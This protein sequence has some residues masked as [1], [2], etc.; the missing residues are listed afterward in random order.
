MDVVFHITE[1]PQIF[2]RNVLL[3]GLHYTR[4]ATV[5]RAI[6]L[7]SGDALNQT[8]LLDTQRNLYDL[9][10][11]NEVNAAVENPTAAN[12][13]DGPAAGHRGSALGA[14]LRYWIRGADRNSAK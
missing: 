8:A 13:Q 14:D 1:G 2:V 5:E 4:P 6:T 12:P 7:H 10:L 9:P 11:F 3:T